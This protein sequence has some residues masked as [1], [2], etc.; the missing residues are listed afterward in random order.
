MNFVV[1]AL[2]KQRSPRNLAFTSSGELQVE[3]Q[4]S[5]NV[6]WEYTG[7]QDWMITKDTCFLLSEIEALH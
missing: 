1:E 5:R 4:K 6:V 7:N 3:L 2:G